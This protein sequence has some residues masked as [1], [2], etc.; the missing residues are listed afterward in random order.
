MIDV[1]SGEIQ[2]CPCGEKP[3]A[4]RI[5]L[6]TKLLKTIFIAI[7]NPETCQTCECCNGC[8]KQFKREGAI[9]KY[10]DKGLRLAQ[11]RKTTKTKEFREK[12]RWRA[13]IEGTNSQYKK[14]TGV[15]RL[16][17]RTLPKVRF[18]A[19]LKALGVNIFRCERARK[20]L[21]ATF[22]SRPQLCRIWFT[23]LSQFPGCL[24]VTVA[25]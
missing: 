2:S 10:S 25:A 3:T 12:Y 22:R 24:V 9:V 4:T 18:A 21:F 6:Q 17:V 15:G 1:N 19:V 11:R 14:Q 5:D 8:P 16:R 13:G 7:F 20:A 23:R